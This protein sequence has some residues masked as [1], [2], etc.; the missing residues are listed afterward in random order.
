LLAD[1]GAAE[2]QQI[3]C[4]QLGWRRSTC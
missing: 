3:E 2:L 1:F 4:T